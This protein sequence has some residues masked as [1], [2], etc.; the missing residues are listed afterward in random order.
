MSLLQGCE[1]TSGVVQDQDMVYAEAADHSASTENQPATTAGTADMV[2]A[3]VG[4]PPDPGPGSAYRV[5]AHDL[6]QVDVFQAEE[7]SRKY[8]V[9]EAGV[10]VMPLVGAV[11]VGR[12]TPPEAQ[13]AIASAL[14]RDYLQDPQVSVFVEE[15]ANL[16]VTVAGAVNKPGVFPL[17]PH[18]TLLQAIALAEGPNRVAQEGQIILFRSEDGRAVQAYVLDLEKIEK[19]ELRDPR[20]LAGDRIVVPE[21]GGLVFVRGVTDVLRGFVRPFYF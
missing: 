13:Q 2:P 18:T 6:L 12:L 1:T 10:I 16:N 9:N 11:E 4:S 7:L 17:T 3:V 15:Y 5:G 19:G 14:Q 21:A 20:L 8:R